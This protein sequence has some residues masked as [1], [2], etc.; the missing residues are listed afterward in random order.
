MSSAAE[1]CLLAPFS[2]C[3][4]LAGFCF[5]CPAHPGRIASNTIIIKHAGAL[6]IGL[7]V[8]LNAFAIIDVA[9]NGSPEPHCPNFRS[10]QP[11][12]K[13]TCAKKPTSFPAQPGV[14]LFQDAGGTIL[15]VG[16]ARSLRSRVKSYFLESRWQD[17]KTGSLVREI[18]DLEY[19]V[20]DNEPKRSRSK[21]I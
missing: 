16:K 18:A 8:P 17:A 2:D 6:L 20:V 15:Y 4:G 9:P 7:S 19:I 21:T 13:W 10:L 12:A 3:A 14:Y 5:C 1:V 11:S